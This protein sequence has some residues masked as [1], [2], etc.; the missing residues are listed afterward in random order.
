MLHVMLSMTFN[1]PINAKP[2]LRR[3]QMGICT[4][5]NLK[6]PAPLRQYNFPHKMQLT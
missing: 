6:D 5:D 1:A 3:A 4:I 2:T